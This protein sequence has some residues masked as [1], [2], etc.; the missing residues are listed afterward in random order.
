MTDLKF[1][2]RSTFGGAEKF[3]HN[4][5][6]IVVWFELVYISDD[7][8]LITTKSISIWAHLIPNIQ[9]VFCYL[10]LHSFAFYLSLTENRLPSLQ[11]PDN[12]TMTTN[13]A[14][15]FRVSANDPG[16]TV[17]YKLAN[18]GKGT[19]QINDATGE[20]TVT[21]NPNTPVT[22]Q[23]VE[24]YMWSYCDLFHLVDCM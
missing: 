16:D 18:D 14:K 11:V 22:L 15:T 4:F 12:V 7:M 10:F 9:S 19:I 2:L 24:C 20:I 17:T 3:I 1:L 23:W 6:S 5:E 8:C 21:V 13:I